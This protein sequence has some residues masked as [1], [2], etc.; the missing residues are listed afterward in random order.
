LGNYYR[1]L[2]GALRNHGI[3]PLGAEQIAGLRPLSDAKDRET[4]AN[5]L[6]RTLGVG[7]DSLIPP[8][9]PKHLRNQW[10]Q[11]RP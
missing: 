3:S 11:H 4:L 7:N 9:V 1:T 2:A 10:K 8:G 6:G 5:L